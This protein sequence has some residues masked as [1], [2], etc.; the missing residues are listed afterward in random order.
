MATGKIK[1]SFF[2][3][4]DNVDEQEIGAVRRLI[5]RILF[6]LLLVADFFI[7]LQCLL[8]FIKGGNVFLFLG[9]VSALAL[10]TGADAVKMFV[11]KRMR[12]KTVCHIIEGIAIFFIAV[13]VGQEHVLAL[14]MLILTELYISSTRMF[15]SIIVCGGAI[16]L[17]ILTFWV[18]LAIRERELSLTLGLGQSYGDAFVLF[19]HFAIITVAF[20]FYQQYLRLKKAMKELDKSKAELQMAYNEL[21]QKTAL[22]ERQRIAKDIHDTAGHSITT[23]IMQTEAAKLIIDKN[24]EEAKN[25]IVAANLQA[26][27]ALEELRDSVHLLS[28]RQG[29]ETLKSSF[30]KIIAESTDGTGI[31]I[32]SDIEELQVFGKKYRFL[33]NA[34]KEG[35]ANGLRHGNATAFWVELKREDKKILFLLSDNG[36]GVDDVKTKGFGL[37]EME[38]V[39]K[40]LGGTLEIYSEKGEGFE[41][42][43]ELPIDKM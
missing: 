22:E 14:Y 17:Y 40:T 33:S 16:F 25:K 18:S 4:F 20:R 19:F 43:I 39:A 29:G 23:V 13:F 7:L 41:I 26:K 15:P 21:E 12:S 24:P 38:R 10:L 31:I 30:E 36:D 32:R 34:L 9:G 27:H 3:N 6:I 8:R 5:K 35:I 42:R 11:L 37:S 1:K 2:E 28:G